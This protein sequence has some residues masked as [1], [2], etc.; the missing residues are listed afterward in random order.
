MILEEDRIS[1]MKVW[2]VKIK[3]PICISWLLLLSLYHTVF[4]MAK[5]NIKYVSKT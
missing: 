2:Y 1:D 4:G 3:A 5:D